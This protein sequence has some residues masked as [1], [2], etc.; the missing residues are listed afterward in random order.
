MKGRRANGIF[1]SHVLFQGV[2]LLTCG[3][4]LY[5]ENEGS[6]ALLSPAGWNYFGR[7]TDSLQGGPPCLEHVTVFAGLQLG[8]DHAPCWL[9]A[10]CSTQFSWAK[11][12]LDACKHAVTAPPLAGLQLDLGLQCQAKMV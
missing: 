6:E 5:E 12:C 2:L 9:S 4:R 8:T 7:D 10:H 11:G 3:N 1:A